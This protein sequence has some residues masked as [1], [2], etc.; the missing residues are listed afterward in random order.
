MYTH[1]FYGTALIPTLLSFK[2]GCKSLNILNFWWL[3]L[4]LQSVLKKKRKKGTSWLSSQHFMFARSEQTVGELWL[5]SLGVTLTFSP[6]LLRN[7]STVRRSSIDTILS[8]L[9]VSSNL[10]CRKKKM[11]RFT[12]TPG[13]INTAQLCGMRQACDRQTT[14]LRTLWLHAHDIFT[15]DMP[16]YRTFSLPIKVFHAPIIE[17][18]L[19]YSIT[20]W[21]SLSPLL[22]KVSSLL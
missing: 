10:K 21:V 17:E 2:K 20:K 15:H 5:R 18:L 3:S 14:R 8:S 22:K 11:I 1:F 7:T 13:P 9:T 19:L 16:K 6:F 4:K 12:M